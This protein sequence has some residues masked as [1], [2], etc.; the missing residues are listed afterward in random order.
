MT[1]STGQTGT[2]GMAGAPATGWFTPEDCDIREF[3]ALV[4]QSTVLADYPFADAVEQNVLIYGPGLADAVAEPAQRRAVQAELAR[5][6]LTGPGVVVFAGA[7]DAGVVDAAT[8]AFNGLLAEQAATDTVVGDHFAK[9][10][11]NGRLW[12]A[13]DKLAAADAEAFVGY[14]ANDVIALVSEAWLGPNY[15]IT[16]QVNVVYP[17]GTAQVPHRDYHLGFM[18]SAQAQAYPAQAHV[19]SPLLTLQGAV[20]H[21]DM[22]LESGPTMLLPYSQLYPQGYVAWHL[23]EFEEYFA[24]HFVQLP[25]TKGDAVFFS[26]ALFHGAG[27]NVTRDVARMANLL[28]VSSAFGRAMETVDTTA[29]CRLVYPALS[30]RVAAGMAPRLVANVVA[31]AAEGYAF[32]T[33]LDLDPPVGSMAP[34]SQAALVHRALDEG[35]EPERLAEELDAQ[36]ARRRSP[37][38]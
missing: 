16:S 9:P 38:A 30:A 20:A 11:A 34:L 12:S 23:P 28:Q 21:S 10:G 32:P 36:Q 1:Q 13:L 7:V 19:L 24:E 27:T 26:P 3:A 31:A 14:Y 2:T 22:T 29:I 33:N 37:L 17:G 35:W 18:D 5:A 15:Q 4:E 8:V 6:L 25:L